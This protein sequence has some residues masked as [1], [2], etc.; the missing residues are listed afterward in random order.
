MGTQ[1]LSCEFKSKQILKGKEKKEKKIFNTLK[2]EKRIVK[3]TIINLK[4]PT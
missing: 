3:T 2:T 4:T 1:P